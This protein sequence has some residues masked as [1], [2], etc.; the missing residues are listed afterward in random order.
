VQI[1]PKSHILWWLKKIPAGDPSPDD[2]DLLLTNDPRLPPKLKTRSASSP[3]ERDLYGNYTE[4]VGPSGP[5][6]K[7]YPMKILKPESFTEALILLYCRDYHNPNIGDGLQLGYDKYWKRLLLPMGEVKVDPKAIVP[8]TL[9][10]EFR[11][12]WANFNLVEQ[13]YFWEFFHDDLRDKLKKQNKLP[14]FPG[15]SRLYQ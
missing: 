11:E 13:P 12:A 9:R 7:I 8:K 3:I 6:E 2:E 15:I 4:E 10:P 14:S 1:F 5:W